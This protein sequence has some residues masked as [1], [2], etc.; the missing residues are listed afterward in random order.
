MVPADHNFAT[1]WVGVAYIVR[2]G[3][4]V[5]YMVVWACAEAANC[6][7]AQVLNVGAFAA[8]AV[9]KIIING[10]NLLITNHWLV[11]I[12]LEVDFF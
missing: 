11:C 7:S 2:L 9:I 4:C 5:R 3:V 12:Y 8:G 1:C 6:P 10:R